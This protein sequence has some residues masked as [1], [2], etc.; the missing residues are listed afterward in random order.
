MII[1]LF[2]RWRSFARLVK[3]SSHF[4]LTAYKEKW[5]I[6]HIVPINSYYTR[7][8]KLKK[9]PIVPD[10]PRYYSRLQFILPV[11][12]L[13]GIN[14][15]CRKYLPLINPKRPH[16]DV[17][18]TSLLFCGWYRRHSRNICFVLGTA[19]LINFRVAYVPNMSRRSFSVVLTPIFATNSVLFGDI[20]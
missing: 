19:N 18:V 5:T 8:Q 14:L 15:G 6:Q 20:V 7:T 16:N 3:S 2:V 1:H 12:S 17:S 11:N 10:R 13:F 9:K 4:H